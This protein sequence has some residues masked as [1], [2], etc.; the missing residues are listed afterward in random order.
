SRPRPLVVLPV[1][2]WQG[3]N[4]FD[5]DLD[6]FPDE[7]TGARRVAL[8]R[9]Y[10]A[11]RLP[12][13]ARTQAVPL[14]AF[15]DRA[16]LPYD[17]TTDV[18]LG[19]DHGPSLANAPA[20]VIAGDARWHAPA[21]A[22]RLRRHVEEEGNRVALFGADSLRRPVQLS[23]ATARDPGGR[24]P[25]DPFGERTEL[26]A[27]GEAPMRVQRRGRGLFGGTDELL[28]SFMR[29]ERSVALEPR[30]R[31]EASAGRGADPALV[32]YRLGR[33]TVVRLGSPG[34]PAELREDRASLEVQRVTRNLWRLLSSAR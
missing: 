15:L 33:G 8:G 6:G 1:V 20:A 28:G 22:R 18:S 7:L 34:W 5:D 10:A 31:L 25:A 16:R 23:G 3:L 13:G 14:L 29:F 2:T 19:E 30:A 12:R 4:R 24:R 9:P 26:V 11:G 17:L 32:G 21:L 27:T